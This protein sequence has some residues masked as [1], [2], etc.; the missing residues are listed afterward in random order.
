MDLEIPIRIEERGT[1]L[2]AKRAAAERSG[3]RFAV[4][5]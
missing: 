5:R 4:Q 2:S 1:M 3:R